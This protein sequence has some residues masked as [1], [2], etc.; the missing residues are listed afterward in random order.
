MKS[1]KMSAIRCFFYWESAGDGE[2][3]GF[4]SEL[5]ELIVDSVYKLELRRPR[6]SMMRDN[7][8]NVD[9]EKCQKRLMGSACCPVWKAWY[10]HR[11]IFI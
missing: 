7:L 10:S 8:Y 5:D 3:N 2:I 1:L 4:M 9:M 11:P 6:K